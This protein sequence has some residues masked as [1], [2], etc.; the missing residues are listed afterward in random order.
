MIHFVLLL[1]CIISVEVS[2]RFHFFSIFNS[3]HEVVKKVIYVIPKENISDHWK[4]IVIP[5]YALKI[6]NLSLKI[7]LIII[8]ILSL[9]IIS[10][11]LLI[12]FISFTV[13]FI[14]IIESLFFA[15]GYI[16]FRKALIK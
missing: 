1:V 16:I 2:L 14:G 7:L 11:I 13:S 5:A 10:D 15:I 3:I 9:F 6:M 8:F 12:G 4:E